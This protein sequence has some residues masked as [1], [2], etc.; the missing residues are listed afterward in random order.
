MDF[1]KYIF[2][3]FINLSKLEFK[4]HILITTIKSIQIG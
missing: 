4:Q 3:I 1:K 2:Y